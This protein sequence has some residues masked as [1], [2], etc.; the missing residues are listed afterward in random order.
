MSAQDRIDE[1]LDQVINGMAEG[2]NHK[3]WLIDQ[4]VRILTGCPTVADGDIRMLGESEE[5]L[6]FVR[7]YQDGEEGP[8]TYTWDTGIAP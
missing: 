1:A 3:M 6:D 5:Y 4:V 2:E 7:D 8:E